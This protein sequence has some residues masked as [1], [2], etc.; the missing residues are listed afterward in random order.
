M[1]GKQTVTPQ[2]G[3]I[4]DVTNVVH[5]APGEMA[6]KADLREGCC[7]LCLRVQLGSSG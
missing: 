6:H 1:A 5:D 2:T 3:V 4:L 7:S